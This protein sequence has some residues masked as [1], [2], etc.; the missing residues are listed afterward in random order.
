LK[1]LINRRKGNQQE[2]FIVA[3]SELKLGC[4]NFCSSN[5]KKFNPC[6]Y[7]FEILYLVNYNLLNFIRKLGYRPQNLSI[8][9]LPIVHIS[10]LCES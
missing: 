2:T 6:S 4:I 8:Y 7:I 10:N 9:T 3:V 1:H 5:V